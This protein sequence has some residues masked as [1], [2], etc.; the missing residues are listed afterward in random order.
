MCSAFSFNIIPDTSTKYSVSSKE[1]A[2]DVVI[3]LRPFTA[4]T[5]FPS[6][7][8]PCVFRVDKV[9]LGETF[10]QAV[11]FSLFSI[12]PLMLPNHIS[13]ILSLRYRN[14]LPLNKTSSDLEVW[15]YVGENA[16]MA[17]SPET[18]TRLF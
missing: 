7:D 18:L 2:M 1:R 16:N 4:T 6:E 14:N 5:L 15:T 12:I 8:S 17:L 11:R 3:S 13:C 10:L 9:T